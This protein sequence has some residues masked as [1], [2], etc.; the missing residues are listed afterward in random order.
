MVTTIASGTRKA[1]KS[2]QCFECYRS[3]GAG[4]TYG[5]QSNVYDGSAYTLSWHLDCAQCAS[6]Y[7]ELTG[8]RYPDEGYPPLRDQWIDNGEYENE[9]GLWRGYFPHVVA[10]MELTD[11]L[12]TDRALIAGGV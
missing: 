6:K 11:Q 9:C 1:R 2:R 7:R 3:I 8:Y 5:Y 10:R 12:R 4:E